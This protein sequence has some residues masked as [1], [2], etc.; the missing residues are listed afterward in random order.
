MAEYKVTIT[1]KALED[2]RKKHIVAPICRIYE[3]DNAYIDMK[4]YDGT[5]YDTNVDGFGNVS[6]P[7]PYA[8]T[9]IPF[10]VPLAQFKLA[11][12]GDGNTV[13]FKVNDY[14][15]AFYYKQVGL[16]MASQGF[17]VA[18]EEVKAAEVTGK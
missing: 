4:A 8:S 3:P 1:Y 14:A 15:E 10:P 2:E 5:V 12:V 17:T 16:A 6:V 13:E 11:A 7:E 18:V 9:S